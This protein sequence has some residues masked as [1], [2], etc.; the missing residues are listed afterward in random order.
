MDF[1]SIGSDGSPPARRDQAPGR[2]RGRQPFERG[3]RL[4]GMSIMQSAAFV[5]IIG[6]SHA[7]MADAPSFSRTRR[8]A[9]GPDLLGPGAGR[10][11]HSD[12][13]RPVSCADTADADATAASAAATM[14]IVFILRDP[15]LKHGKARGEPKFAE[16]PSVQPR[17]AGGCV[18]GGIV[19]P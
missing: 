15:W 19:R 4:P 12:P 14:R 3:A 2:K 5:F 6:Q 16:R 13:L 17:R 8:G 10:V 11:F 9:T 7:A 1:P 18:S